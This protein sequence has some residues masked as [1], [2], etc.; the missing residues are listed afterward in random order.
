MVRNNGNV[1]NEKH[2]L[3]DPEYG[4]KPEKRG[5]GDTHVVGHG[6][7]RETLKNLEKEK[8][9]NQEIKYAKN[10]EKCEMHT[11]GAG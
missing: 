4:K 8:C 7:W 1:E 11:V 10:P 2:T 6:I 5:K 9:K 3:Q